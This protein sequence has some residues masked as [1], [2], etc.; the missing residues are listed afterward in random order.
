MQL[1]Y[2]EA[3]SQILETTE[4]A[5]TRKSQDKLWTYFMLDT[6]EPDMGVRCMP[7]YPF[8]TENGSEGWVYGIAEE[9]TFWTSRAEAEKAAKQARD[10]G[11]VYVL[12]WGDSARWGEE[13]L[14][15]VPCKPRFVGSVEAIA[16]LREVRNG[17]AR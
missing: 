15:G 1:T 2:G 17:A 16:A 8:E 11:H 13:A 12:N 3:V 14:T 4:V 6:T 5:Y 9:V 7:I 10:K